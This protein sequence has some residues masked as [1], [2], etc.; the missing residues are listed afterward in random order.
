[1]NISRYVLKKIS[2]F[3][4][5]KGFQLSGTSYFYIL[6]DVAYC[7]TIDS[8]ALLYATAYVMP[9]YI[10][11]E[12]RYYT[13]GS[14]SN[15]WPEKKLPPLRRDSTLEAINVWCDALCHCIEKT[16]LPF[17]RQIATPKKLIKYAKRNFFYA[18]SVCFVARRFFVS[19]LQCMAIS[20]WGVIAKRS[21][22]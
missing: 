9:L 7:L 1:M 6:N 4:Q 8:G 5:S 13:Y 15:E 22:R 17:Y 14:R 18:A 3:M 19:A 16:I 21:L 12:A 10:P 11:S 2:P 20:I